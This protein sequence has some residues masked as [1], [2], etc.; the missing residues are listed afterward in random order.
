MN[1][2]AFCKI[3]PGKPAVSLSFPA[4]FLTKTLL[5]MKITAFIILAACLHVSAHGYSQKKITLSV[6]EVPLEKVFK[7]IQKQSGYSFWYKTQ[8][9]DKATRITLSLKDATLQE[10]L[11]KC[12]EN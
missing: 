7:E 5:V 10:V 2:I 4:R 12:F 9:L 1:P 11:A 8:Q 6:H 3:G